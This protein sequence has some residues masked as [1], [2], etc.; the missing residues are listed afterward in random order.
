M[1]LEVDVLVENG[2]FLYIGEG[3][4]RLGEGA[5][6]DLNKVMDKIR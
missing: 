1:Q 2:N 3:K 5:L 4:T 6:L